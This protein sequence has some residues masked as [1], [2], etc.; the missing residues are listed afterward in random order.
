MADWTRFEKDWSNAAFGELLV[1]EIAKIYEISK[2]EKD[3]ISLIKKYVYK[4]TDCG[5]FVEFDEKGVV[6]G[7]IVEGSDA[8]YH[9]RLDVSDIEDSEDPGA[10]IRARFYGAL[11]RCED[12]AEEHFD[13]DGTE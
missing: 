8:M 11:Q 13:N 9:E 6:V 3:P 5:A 1:R 7:T 2:D 10:V 12:F 4:F